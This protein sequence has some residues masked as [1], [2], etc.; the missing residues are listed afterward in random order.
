MQ[1]H[2]PDRERPQLVAVSHLP[3]NLINLQQSRAM[4]PL[5]PFFRPGTRSFV[6][7]LPRIHTLVSLAALLVQA[8]A[9][10]RDVLKQMVCHAVR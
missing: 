2:R 4:P 9:G 3:W 10:E 6:T 5:R 8:N 1:M 7:N